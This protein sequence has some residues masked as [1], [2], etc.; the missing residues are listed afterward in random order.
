MPFT[1]VLQPTQPSVQW[2][3]GLSWGEKWWVHGIDN[4]SGSEVKEEVVYLC[5]LLGLCGLL[6]GKHFTFC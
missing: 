1:L 2:I 6:L 4:P 5:S 3:L